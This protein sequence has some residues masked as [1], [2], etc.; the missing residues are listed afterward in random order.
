[1]SAGVRRLAPL[2][3]LG[4]V[5]VVLLF[6]APAAADDGWVID[7]FV[8]D[9]EI[10]RDG[11][12]NITE[13]IDVDFLSLQ[14]RHGIF[15]VIPVRYQWDADPKML[16]VY[17]LDVRSVRDATGRSLAYETSEGNGPNLSIR[18]GHADR[19]VTG[20][21][22]YRINYTVRGALNPFADHDELFWNV[23]GG[24][25]D[26][27]MRVVTATVHSAFDAF[28]SVT[29]FEGPR[30][31]TRA[32]RSEFSPRQ[33]AFTTS[34]LPAGDQLTIVTALRKGAVTE[35][36]PML[37]R[38]DREI[39]EY[40]EA[41]PFTVGGALITMLGGLALVGRRWWTAGRDE[42]EHETIVAEYEPPEKIRPA[43]AGLLMDESADT[44]DVTA[45]IV[46][47]A[48]RGYL[49]ITELPASGILGLGDKDWTLTRTPGKAD[50]DALQPYERTIYDGLF[51]RGALDL[52]QAA[53][54]G[55]IR[56]F[57]DR[58]GAA[59]ETRAEFETEPTDE[60]KLSALKKRFYTTLAKAQRELYGDSVARKWFAA[61]PQRV[62]Q[63]YAGLGVGAVVVAG[64]LVFGLGSSLGA[65]LVGLGLVVPAV[66]LL[67]VAPRMPRKTRTG[68]EL[69]RRTLGFRH[70]MEIAEKERQRFAERENIFSEYLPY[71]IVFGCVEKW[72]NAFKDIDATQ[73]T[74]SWYTGSSLGAFSANDLSSNL[75]SFSNQVSSTIASTPGGSGGSGFSGGGGG[76]SGGGGGGGGGG[77]W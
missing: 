19:I 58:A 56:R 40:F 35:P 64:F 53:V 46:D 10:Q 15:R 30:G 37:Q 69:H 9:I 65:G 20:K 11:T 52:A 74:S 33:A 29:C 67:A 62:R 25:W 26:V 42:R 28:T 4:A 45:T 48:V 16:R 8:A 1:M 77:S 71:A 5:A 39:E 17:D 44:K 63:I 73:A 68:A 34:A 60:V 66:A 43:Q 75:S 55:L 76:G 49:R 38:R 23:N 50:P 57:S 21:Q 6:A 2:A 54:V 24:D 47:L 22:A 27:P 72:A 13:S 59:E 51:G 31:S 12:L 3:L 18:I 61:D 7:R 36:V 70:Y 41:T 32:C 14:D